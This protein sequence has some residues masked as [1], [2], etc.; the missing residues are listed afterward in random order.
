MIGA[1]VIQ[2]KTLK[3]SVLSLCALALAR[4]RYTGGWL[5][6]LKHGDASEHWADGS[7]FEGERRPPETPRG[8]NTQPV[9]FPA[10]SALFPWPLARSLRGGQEAGCG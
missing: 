1:T 5:D 9:V 4:W 8:W 6:D 10:L 7:R 2:C 3:P